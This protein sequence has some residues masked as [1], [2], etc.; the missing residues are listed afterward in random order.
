MSSYDI[1]IVGA[2]VV[3]L[4]TA[5]AL[6]QKTSL[7]IA[8][9]DM[10]TLTS[11]TLT[12]TSKGRVSAIS[13]SSKNIFENL[14]VWQDM[15]KAG[16]S[17]Y[18]KMLVWDA[19]GKGEIEF[20]SAKL[21]CATLGYIID[22]NVMRASLLA[23]L[24][25]C[26][27]IELIA[28]LNLIRLEETAQS[29]NLVTDFGL[30][31]SAKLLIAADGGDSWVRHQALITTQNYSYQHTAIVTSV[32]TSFP[33]QKT[34]RQCFLPSGPLAFLPLADEFTSSIVWST[35]PQQA[36]LLMGYDD[37][38]FANELAHA[39]SHRLGDV[40]LQGPRLSFPLHM[41]HAQQYI[42]PRLA[43]IGDAAHT[44]H[45]LAGQGVNMGL[46]DAAQLV[47]V[48]A[49]AQTK[50]R[51]FA[52]AANLRSYERNRK[53]D[54]AILLKAVQSLKNLFASENKLV[55]QLRNLGLSSVN[56]LDFLKNFLVSYA[57]GQRSNLPSLV[58]PNL[59]YTG[60]NAKIDLSV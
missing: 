48:I 15:C 27:S 24:K 25:Q 9:V 6:A 11:A 41:R 51:D 46:M 10:H 4:T 56:H 30:T 50:S 59:S 1:V 13:P 57:A 53:V 60:N 44:I 31:L 7:S 38:K 35:L 29:I 36:E 16:I 45:P 21:G 42:K 26:T 58:K 3:G 52:S 23:K 8:L 32:K 19:S 43:L 47:D 34:A 49:N 20:D 37:M 55:C 12:E 17:C 54:N 2:G 33:H 28:P 5:L 40:S 39:F 18:E 22:D 14:Q